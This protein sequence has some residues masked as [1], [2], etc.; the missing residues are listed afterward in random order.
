[1]T[2]LMQI[3]NCIADKIR[4]AVIGTPFEGVK[5]SNSDLTEGFERPSFK[6]EFENST[7]DNLNSN[8]LDRNLTV[9]IYFFASDIKKYKVENLKVQDLLESEF[10][11][12][13]KFD[14]DFIW[15]HDIES[16]IADSV[17]QLGFDISTQFL[18]R[19]SEIENAEYM[20]DL[21]LNI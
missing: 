16:T 3:H 8:F 2:S 17:L 6:I 21:Q 4:N 1:M 7:L 11:G 12:G 20:E 5:I 18:K 19:K 13:L 14:D 10:I 9:R 15:I